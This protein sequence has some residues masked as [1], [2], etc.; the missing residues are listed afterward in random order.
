LSA[1]KRSFLRYY[2]AKGL[3]GPTPDIS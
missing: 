3:P 1:L 2:K